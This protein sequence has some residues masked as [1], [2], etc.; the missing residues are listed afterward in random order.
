MRTSEVIDKFLNKEFNYKAS[1]LYSK[2]NKLIYFKTVIAQWFDDFLLINN[3]Q[4]SRST[5]VHQN[6]L[7]I[8]AVNKDID[9]DV[10]YK[11][12]INTNNLKYFYY[13]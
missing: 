10:V 7:Q 3:T 2:D 6:K 1:N 13:G 8:E 11:I 5:S 4:Y 12:P 9:W